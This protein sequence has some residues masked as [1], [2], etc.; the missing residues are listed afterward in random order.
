MAIIPADL[1]LSFYDEA[2]NITTSISTQTDNVNPVTSAGTQYTMQDV[3][4]TVNA[5]STAVSGTGVNN[6]V[7]VWSGTNTITEDASNKFYYFP[8]SGSLGLGTSS[9][10]FKM[11]IAGGDLRMEQNFGVRFGGTG[12]N[13]QNWNIRTT[14]DP[15]GG[16]YPGAFMI[17]RGGGSNDPYFS[18]T[19][20]SFSANNPG[21]T[22]LHKYGSGNFTGTPAS[23]LEVDSN[24]NI[25][26]SQ[27]LTNAADDAA[28]AAA[29]VPVNGLYRDGNNVKIRLT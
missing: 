27:A 15:F 25:I 7:A 2:K 21:Q 29:G 1:S 18:I 13:G 11:D 6:T 20:G 5:T 9:P 23:R 24:G 17:G 4:D 16:N 10:N 12:S 26:E 8:A 22:R 3:I 19:T 28:A 14:G